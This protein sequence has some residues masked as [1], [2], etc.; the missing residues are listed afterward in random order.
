MSKI[1]DFGGWKM[2]VVGDDL[3]V[4]M[5]AEER[6]AWAYLMT[7]VVTTGGYLAVMLPRLLTTPV[8]QISWVGPLL[9]TLGLSMVGNIVVTMVLAMAS[10]AGC[11]DGEVT[12]DVRD[13]EIGRRGG[14]AL[15]VALSAGFVG[16]L[17]LAMLD[18]DTFWIGNL[19]FLCGA[20]GAVAETTTKIRLYRRGF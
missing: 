16:A 6:A 15:M 3:P 5:V 19:L 18:A 1:L 20:A 4:P 7:V 2:A 11:P 10:R 14:S 12:A 13:R 8:E 17:G 9:W